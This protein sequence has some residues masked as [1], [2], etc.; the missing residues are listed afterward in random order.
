MHRQRPSINQRRVRSR[1]GS[2]IVEFAAG[3]CILV[4]F[5]IVP[6][7]DLAVLPVR[8]MLAQELVND[9][10]RKLAL[11]ENFSQSF[12]RLHA[13]PSLKT[14]LQ[15]L[16]G[17]LVRDVDLQMRISRVA[18]QSTTRDEIVWNRPLNLPA[19]WLPDGA[20][21]PCAYSLE[22]LVHASIAPAIIFPI[23]GISVP[24]LTC[25][26]PVVISASHTW[27]NLGRNPS[28]GNFFVNE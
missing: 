21:S 7:I 1:T 26:V 13:D 23:E 12:E 9:Y 2:H 15:K 20:K 8:W 25:P 28:T 16:G 4:G 18:A 6:L 11:S 10:T 24:G 22:L 5:V 27:G 19:A 14:R 3:I 17:V